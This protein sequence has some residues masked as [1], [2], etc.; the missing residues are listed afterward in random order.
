MATYMLSTATNAKQVFDDMLHLRSLTKSYWFSR[1]LMGEDKVEPGVDRKR[2]MPNSPVVLKQEFGKARMGD[3]IIMT[4]GSKITGAGVGT[5]TTRKDAGATP[6]ER[7]HT[8]YVSDW[9]HGVKVDDFNISQVRA[10][11]DIYKR[12]MR[13]MDDWWAQK[14]DTDIF[15]TFY[16]R[17]SKNNVGNSITGAAVTFHP[18]WFFP[19]GAPIGWTSSAEGALNVQHKMSTRVLNF[20]K[21]Y[22]LDND[23]LPAAYV[24]GEPAFGVVMSESQWTALFE[25]STFYG[26]L[27]DALP[28][29]QGNPLFTGA[30]G[31]WNG[32][33]IHTSNWI[34]DATG[35]WKF[36]DTAVAGDG[37]AGGKNVKRAIFFGGSAVA[38]GI[39]SKVTP[40]V[41]YDDDHQRVIEHGAESIYGARRYDWGGSIGTIN[42]AIVST[43]AEPSYQAQ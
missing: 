13:G 37:S 6:A 24:Q 1:N 7:T 25:D 15:Y 2:D 4:M 20:L 29:A 27:K 33:F 35:T 42:S 31:Y 36:D 38:M 19:T 17:D 10:P 34:Q 18:N 41:R 21:E 32:I 40:T 43:Y 30:K 11:F 28:R 8:V 16:Y 26:S 39:G 23:W 3:R 22:A 5:G 14:F 12:M 9:W